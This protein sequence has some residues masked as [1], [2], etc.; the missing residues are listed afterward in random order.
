MTGKPTTYVA[1]LRGINVGG[2]AKVEMTKLKAAFEDVGL[3]NVKTYINS[4]NVIFCDKSHSSRELAQLI[5]HM[6]EKNFGLNIKVLVRNFANIQAIT[7][8]LPAAWTNDKA[9]KCDVMFLWEDIDS[10]KIV[11]QVA[12]KPEIEDVIYTNGTLIWRI[13]RSNVTKGSSIKLIKTELY[14][15]MTVRNCNT[16]RKICELMQSI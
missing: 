15:K 1:L 8:A 6:V 7:Q 9:M 10:P 14:K 2:S 4:G 13:D 16:V 5:E 11:K 12:W 3:T